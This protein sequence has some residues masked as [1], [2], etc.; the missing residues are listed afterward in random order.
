MLDASNQA[1]IQYG[2]IANSQLGQVAGNLST[3]FDVS[4]LGPVP[5]AGNQ[6]WQ[7]AY[8]S[9]IQR[10]QPQ[11]DQQRAALETR[12]AN[13]GIDI[14]SAAYASAMD[15][16]NR[17]QNDF[18][19][20]AQ[21]QAMSQQQAQ[22]GMD[23][24]AYNQALQASLMARQTP[25]NELAALLSGAQVQQPNYV[26]TGQYQ[27]NP[28]DIMGAIY[29]NY[30][31]Q[32]NAY[33]AQLQNQAA[34]RQGLFDLLGSGAMASAYMWSDRRLKR[35]IIRI[36]ERNGLPLYVWRYVWGATGIG[37][38]ADEVRKVRPDAVMRVGAFDAVNYGALA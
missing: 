7:R 23:Q 3:P 26:S 21:N 20:G 14:G 17:A 13:Q 32:L 5:V 18:R 37:H 1:G 2:Q 35:D 27:V 33:N 34:N 8:D 15:D 29:G 19:L 10:N 6:G 24:A 31:G 4:A 11:M 30:N 36:G 28:A 22:L 12:L 25:I 38:M 9:I 16:F